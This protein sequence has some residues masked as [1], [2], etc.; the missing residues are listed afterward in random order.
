[1]QQELQYI[2]ILKIE[3]FSVNI[4]ILVGMDLL[5]KSYRCAAGGLY[6]L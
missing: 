5:R 1:M 6:I 2:Y 4:I 3:K